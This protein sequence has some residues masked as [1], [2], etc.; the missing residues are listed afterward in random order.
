M[1]P[2]TSPLLLRMS[3]AVTL[4][5]AWTATG[6]VSVLKQDNDAGSGTRVREDAG[7]ITLNLTRL[8]ADNANLLDVPFKTISTAGGGAIQGEA[9]T[10]NEISAR[11]GVFNGEF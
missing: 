6:S 1:I 11:G 10:S 3:I 8:V 9:L 2:S 4:L 5:F 7:H